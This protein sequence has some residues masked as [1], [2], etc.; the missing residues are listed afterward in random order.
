M[1]VFGWVVKQFELKE[2]KRRKYGAVCFVLL[3]DF[4]FF[5]LSATKIFLNLNF[6]FVR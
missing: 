5:Y 4:E 6:P 2:K 1:Q 3:R